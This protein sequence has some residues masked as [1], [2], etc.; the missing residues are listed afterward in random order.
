MARDAELPWEPG[1]AETWAESVMWLTSLVDS[2]HVEPLGPAPERVRYHRPC[3]AG[4][5]DPDLAFLARLLGDRLAPGSGEE[6]CGLGGVLQLA[7]PKLSRAV[8]GDL[9]RK[10]APAPGEPVLTGCSGCVLQLTATAP[11]G[12]AVGH[13]L[14]IFDVTP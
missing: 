8:A 11:R 5:N 2:L 4:T 14:E 12:T 10:L 7:A 13:W 9:W 3:H 6:C 1:E